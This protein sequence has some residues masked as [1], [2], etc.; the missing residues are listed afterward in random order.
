MKMHYYYDLYFVMI[1]IL[2]L[3]FL[4]VVILIHIQIDH[5]DHQMDPKNDR[6]T[7]NEFST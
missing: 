7:K 6:E 4:N 5:D 1:Q 3:I 2:F